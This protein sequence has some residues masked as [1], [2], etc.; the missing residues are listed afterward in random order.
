MSCCVYRVYDS[1]DDL[2]YVG[3][4][5]RPERRVEDHRRRQPWGD[6]IATYTVEEL[7]ARDLAL[8]YERRSI[9]AERPKHNARHNPDWDA[10]TGPRIPGA[11]S[12]IVP[13]T[14]SVP[15]DVADEVKRLA[16]GAERS[17]AAQVRV[18][19]RQHIKDERAKKDAA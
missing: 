13:I 17:F 6:Q 3:C 7:P 9:I 15:R 10:S 11:E 12:G 8:A 1:S 19:L 5:V 4:S 2:L 18:A 14:V 16:E